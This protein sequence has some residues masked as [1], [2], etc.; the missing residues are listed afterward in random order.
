[1]A[2]VEKRGEIRSRDKLLLLHAARGE[3]LTNASVRDL[4]KVDSTH[5]RAALQ[6]LRD[7]GYLQQSG[8][9]GGASYLLAKELSPP[10]GIQLSATE[11]EDLVVVLATE[12]RITNERLRARTGLDRGEALALLS[13]LVKTGRI[14][15]H[16][17][18]R[19]TYYTA[20]EHTPDARPN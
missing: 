2:E 13:R 5:A 15:R 4:L 18:R 3:L 16:G 11:L 17:E 19:G 12:G 10:S 9:R 20:A 6:K 7:L 14:Q 1:M 8:E